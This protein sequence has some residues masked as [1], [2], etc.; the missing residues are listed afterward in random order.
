MRYWKPV[1]TGI[2]H[3][4][5]TQMVTMLAGGEPALDAGYRL[6]RPLSP[7]LS[8]RLAGVTIDTD[9]LMALAASQTDDERFIVEGAGGA[10]V[11]LNDSQFMFDLMRHLGLP[12]LVVSRST[13]GTINHT[14]LTLEALRAR[15]LTVAGVILNGPPNDDNRQAIECFG[16]VE[17][18]AQLPP[19]ERITRETIAD[20]AARID[21]HDRLVSRIFA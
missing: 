16:Q 11:P 13:L 3:D 10:Y 7:H 19:Y 20:M 14:L 9:V 17:V 12:V 6:P 1:Q 18:L 4:D 21:P 15:G 2:E 8:A 5:D